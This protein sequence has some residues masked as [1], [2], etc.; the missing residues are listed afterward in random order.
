MGNAIKKLPPVLTL[1]LKR[2]DFDYN[3]MQQVKVNTKHDF[4][5]ELDMTEFVSPEY[6]KSLPE[7]YLKYELQSILIHRG[8]C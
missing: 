5:L 7:N 3:F 1:G 2:F 8:S 6:A 4:P